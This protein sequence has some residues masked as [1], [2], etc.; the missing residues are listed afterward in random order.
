M[1]EIADYMP[2]DAVVMTGNPPMF[3]YHTGMAAISLPNEP[4]EEGLQT[5][6]R[7][8]G[9]G[10]LLLDFDHPAT[11]DSVWS[12]REVPGNFELVADFR[13]DDDSLCSR[14]RQLREDNQAANEQGCLVFRLFRIVEEASS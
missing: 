13:S 8:F 2:I 12:G 14:Q 4:A 11:V 1:A 6:I 10:Y 5:A 3:Y 9:V 7:D